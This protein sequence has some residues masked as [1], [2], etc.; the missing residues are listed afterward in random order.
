MKNKSSNYL[1]KEKGA[2]TIIM[3]RILSKRPSICILQI[4]FT[5]DSFAVEGH[6]HVTLLP[7]HLIL[8]YVG[9]NTQ[10]LLHRMN[11]HGYVV[12]SNYKNTLNSNH[13]GEEGH[14]I[15]DIS[16]KHSI[17]SSVNVDT[18]VVSSSSCVS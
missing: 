7:S 12:S 8:P 4:F 14:T 13:F 16:V 9:F 1:V 18:S 11:C 2:R 5:I 10:E 6:C 15:E 17:W 3:P